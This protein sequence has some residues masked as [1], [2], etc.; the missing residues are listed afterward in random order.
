MATGTRLADHFQDARPILLAN[1]GRVV[2]V[3]ADSGEYSAMGGC[4][5]ECPGTR[6]GGCADGDDLGHAFLGSSI[7]NCREVGP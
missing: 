1:F 3:D 4:E 5:L 6:G 7:K 2:G